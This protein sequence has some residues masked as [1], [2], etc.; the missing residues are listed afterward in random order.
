MYIS[1][2]KLPNRTICFIGFHDGS[3]KRTSHATHLNLWPK[4]R[5]FH[6]ITLAFNSMFKMNPEEFIIKTGLIIN[7]FAIT[8]DVF[9]RV[10]AEYLVLDIDGILVPFYLEEYR[11]R[12]MVSMSGLTA[13][14]RFMMASVFRASEVPVM[15]GSVSKP[16]AAGSV[17][18]E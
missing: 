14:M 2:V 4:F 17:T 1:G 16:A 12:P 10:D 7:A 11:F 15:F 3:P 5:N 13:R 8:D 18:A 9:D 6:I